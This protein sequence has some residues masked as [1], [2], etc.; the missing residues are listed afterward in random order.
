VLLVERPLAEL[1]IP[2]DL[3]RDV[4]CC[5]DP[6]E[7]ARHHL[8]N[9]GEERFVREGDLELEVVRQDDRPIGLCGYVLRNPGEVGREEGR[10]LLDR[11]EQVAGAQSIAEQHDLLTVG[12]VPG[13]FAARCRHVAA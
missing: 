12:E 9:L 2:V 3:A 11:I 4:A 1:E 5:V 6:H 10:V 8:A 7:L 13:E